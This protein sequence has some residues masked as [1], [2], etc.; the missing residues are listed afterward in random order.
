MGPSP[1]LR[2]KEIHCFTRIESR[3]PSVTTGSEHILNVVH[4][5]VASDDLEGKKKAVYPIKNGYLTEKGWPPT[6]NFQ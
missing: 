4:G 1:I 6:K 3:V 2:F 5:V